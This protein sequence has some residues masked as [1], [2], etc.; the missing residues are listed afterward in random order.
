MRHFEL[1]KNQAGA[2]V[3]SRRELGIS[4]EE[5]QAVRAFPVSAPGHGIALQDRNGQELEWIA[6]LASL[7]EP[8]RQLLLDALKQREFMPEI[9][10]LCHVSSLNTPSVWQVETDRGPTSLTLQG[11]EHLRRIGSDTLLIS[12]AEGVW[13]LIRDMQGLDAYSRKM[14]D[15]FM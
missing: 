14:L 6:D 13:F 5:V 9:Q 15:R 12:T 7:T 10:R 4:F 3:Y 1:R 8:N 11:E 2:L